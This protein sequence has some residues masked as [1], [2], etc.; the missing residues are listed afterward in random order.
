MTTDQLTQL[1]DEHNAEFLKFERVEH[2][3][4]NRPDLHAFLLLST[5]KSGWT[6]RLTIS[7]RKRQGNR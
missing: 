3:R 1:F 2:K 6:L 7:P 4:S 5:T